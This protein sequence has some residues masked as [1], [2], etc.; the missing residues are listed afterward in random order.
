MTTSPLSIGDASG[1]PCN[2]MPMSYAPPADPMEPHLCQVSEESDLGSLLEAA[3][4]VRLQSQQR[5]RLGTA[6]R[7]EL[8]T[9]RLAA[10]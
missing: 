1:I 2:P 10:A 3:A 9:R 7:L 6:D 5:V 8:P 4:A